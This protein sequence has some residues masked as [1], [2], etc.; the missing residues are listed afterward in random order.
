[1]VPLCLFRKQ[2]YLDTVPLPL[3]M[4]DVN[5]AMLRGVSINCLEKRGR[6]QDGSW[7]AGG[8]T[9]WWFGKHSEF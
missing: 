2:P 9:L 7:V 1:M 8:V 6:E 4:L 3:I 5:L